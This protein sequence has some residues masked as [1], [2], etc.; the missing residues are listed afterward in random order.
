MSESPSDVSGENLAR[1]DDDLPL[2]DRVLAGDAKAFEELVRRHEQRV[3]RVA[4]GITA[5]HEDAEE[6]MQQ[7]FLKVHQHV[8]EFHG[9]SKFS[10]WMTRIAINEALQIRRRR[11]PNVSL[12]ELQDT[13]DGSLP[14]ELRDWHDNPAQVFEK[15][16]IRE[17]V[18]AAI[19]SLPPLYR[20]AFVL[21]DVEGFTTEEA[22]AALGIS[23]TALKTRLLRA[24]LMM[25]DALAVFLQRKPT[26]ASRA[27][28]V[29][30]K[31]QDALLAGM[32]RAWKRA[33]GGGP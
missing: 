3:Y 29:R 18:E 19:Q 4:M 10:T 20:D 12:D 15:T 7:T 33:D 5:N 1:G 14:K 27:S 6:A 2:L 8:S 31:I 21:R 28:Q 17:I 16:R 26:L 23:Q 9:S 11:R 24:R 32:R 25:R 13:K 22:A 30:W